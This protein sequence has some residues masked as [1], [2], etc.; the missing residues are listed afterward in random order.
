[1]SGGEEEIKS[2]E[3][4]QETKGMGMEKK[5]KGKWIIWDKL[6]TVSVF[7]LWK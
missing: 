5:M 4:I 1:L 7:R 2:E 3:R 6:C